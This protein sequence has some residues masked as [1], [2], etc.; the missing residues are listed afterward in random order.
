MCLRAFEGVANVRGFSSLEQETILCRHRSISSANEHGMDV[1]LIFY[2]PDSN[3][4]M[5]IDEELV[6]HIAEVLSVDNQSST[7]HVQV[8]SA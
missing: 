4:I 1:D 5:G 8:L 3:L 6:L 7:A 2:H